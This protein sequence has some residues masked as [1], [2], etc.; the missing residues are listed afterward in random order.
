MFEPVKFHQ[1][2]DIVLH[3][4]RA[5]ELVKKQIDFIFSWRKW[6]ELLSTDNFTN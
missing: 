2:I 4:P 3:P 5:E 1:E 6:I